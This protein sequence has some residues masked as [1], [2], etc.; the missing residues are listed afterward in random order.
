METR[1]QKYTYVIVFIPWLS[2][3][4]FEGIGL[5]LPLIYAYASQVYLNKEYAI[6]LRNA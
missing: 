5:V 4:N 3:E 2:L 1:R 6:A